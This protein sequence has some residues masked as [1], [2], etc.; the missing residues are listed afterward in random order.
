MHFQ[1]TK[2]RNVEQTRKAMHVLFKRIRNLD[3]QIDLQLYLFHHVILPIALYG[4]EIWGFE[5]SQ[6]IENLH[7]D[8]LRQIIILIKSTP[9]Y[10]ERNF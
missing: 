8:F 10:T 1:Q 6:N 3:I 4:C 9:I 5:S 7:N 2:K